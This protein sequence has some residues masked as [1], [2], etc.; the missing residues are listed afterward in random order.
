MPT[1]CL[2]NFS[3]GLGGDRVCSCGLLDCLASKCN[4]AC[5]EQ[6][7]TLFVLKNNTQDLLRFNTCINLGRETIA[8]QKTLV[9]SGAST[10]FMSNQLYERIRATGNR[11]YILGKNIGW[12]QVTAAGDR[13]SVG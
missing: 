1:E 2:N 13:K 9:D 12:M 3:V 5:V 7:D 11:G 8:A 4:S 10:N 6:I